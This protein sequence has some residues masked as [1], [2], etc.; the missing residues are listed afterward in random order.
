MSRSIK[1]IEHSNDYD[2]YYSFIDKS[3]AIKQHGVFGMRWGI[4]KY[5]NKDGSLTPA[6][7][8]H[9]GVGT[10]S[11]AEVI[12]KVARDRA[13]AHKRTKNAAIWTLLLGPAAGAVAA[14]L[15]KTEGAGYEKLVQEYKDDSEFQNLK[16]TLEDEAHT[17]ISEYEQDIQKLKDAGN[18]AGDNAKKIVNDINNNPGVK[19]AKEEIKNLAND[20]KEN[21]Q[22][23]TDNSSEPI[24]EKRAKELGYSSAKEYVEE[25]Y[26]YDADDDA[27]GEYGHHEQIMKDYGL[28][29]S[30]FAMDHD[31]EIV[32]KDGKYFEVTLPN[33]KKHSY[34][35][36]W[37]IDSA[38]DRGAKPVN[39][40]NSSKEIP[41]KY[42]KGSSE[43]DFNR[44][45]R[46][47]QA[48]RVESMKK[49]GMTA[50]EIAKKLN[51]PVGTVNSYLYS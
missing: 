33:G 45:V 14:A 20:V 50:E 42:R 38:Y 17:P 48:K 47:R 46:E 10:K 7:R 18:K 1:V 34:E 31:G 3:E 43:S 25:N 49:S 39:S 51:M 37:E 6:G 9:Y 15:T 30:D 19:V 2:Q 26:P 40:Q 11:N 28:K 12:D 44:S 21:F 24:H 16:K 23:T 4:R 8:A 27:L 32:R 29:K 22:K 5:Q 35:H 13:S 41:N 36:L